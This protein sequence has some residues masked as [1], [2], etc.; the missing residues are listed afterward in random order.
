MK[1]EETLND[2]LKPYLK[3]A[4][5]RKEE[6]DPWNKFVSEQEDYLKEKRKNKQLWGK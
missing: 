1:K 4:R 5:E 3:K 2:F 6:E